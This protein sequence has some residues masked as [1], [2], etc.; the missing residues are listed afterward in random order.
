MGDKSKLVSFGI[1]ESSH[2]Q[3]QP[4]LQAWK[5]LKVLNPFDGSLQFQQSEI[6]LNS[7]GFQIQYIVVIFKLYLFIGL[8]IVQILHYYNTV[9]IPHELHI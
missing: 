1:D 7:I 4:T 2:C 8:F 5:E 3:S 6:M 9:Q